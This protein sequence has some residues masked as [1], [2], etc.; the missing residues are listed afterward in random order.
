MMSENQIDLAFVQEPY[1][2]RNNLAGIP[3]SLRT[4]ES[5]N[6]RER[7]ALLVNNKELDQS[8]I[9]SPTDALFGS[10]LPNSA[11]HTPRRT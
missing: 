4:Y 1:N 3:K 6:G 11:T 7:S 10:L 5:G 9:Y 8:F 2:I